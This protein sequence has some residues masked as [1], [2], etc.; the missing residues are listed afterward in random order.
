M[1]QEESRAKAGALTMNSDGLRGWKLAA[2]AALLL[3]VLAFPLYVIKEARR[4]CKTSAGESAAAT[5]VGRE[6]C[7]KCHAKAAEKWRGS[8]HDKA[9]AV[10]SEATVRGDFNNVTFEHNGVTSRFY[11]RDGRY[12]VQTEGARG[13]MAEFEVAYTFGFEPLQQYLVRFPGGRLQALSIAWDVERQRWFHLYP[14]QRIPAGDW[15]HWTRNAQ[16]WNGMCAECH[17]TDLRKGYD[18]KT[19]TY[20]TTWSEIDVSCEAC[21]GPGSL[22]VR[23][24]EIQPMARPEVENYG[25]VVRTQGTTARQQVELCAPCHSRRSE[26]GDYDHRGGDLLDTLLPVS[27]EQGLYFADGQIHDEV[28]EYGSFVQSKMFRSGVRC[29]DCHDVH[30]LKLLEPG[31]ALCLRCHRADTYDSYDHHFHKKVHDGKPSDGALCVKCHMPERPYMVID[32]RADHSIRVPRP[33]LTAQIGVPNA[34]AQSGCH[35]DKP[36]QWS[37]D[38]YTKWYGQA[39]KPHYGTILAAGRAHAPE[40]GGELGRLVQNPLYPPIVRATALSLLREYPGEETTRVLSQA[41]ADEESLVRRTAAASLSIQDARRFTGLLTPLL[42]DP[43]RGVRMEAAARLAGVSRDLLK[44]YQKEAFDRALAEYRDA[45]EH[46]LDFS[47]AGLNLGNLYTSLGRPDE[48]EKYYRTALQ[49]DDLFYPAKMNLAVLLNGEGRNEEAEKLLREVLNAYP[50][51]HEAAYSLGLLLAEMN[52][53]AEAADIL[54]QAAQGMPANARL[55]YNL[56]LLLQHLQRDA[57][58]EAELQTALDLEPQNVDYLYA[59]ADFYAKRGRFD[60][61]SSMAERMVAAQPD[62]RMGH[63]LKALIERMRKPSAV[64]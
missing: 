31:N 20:N 12:F 8:D 19:D 21:H 58:A 10:A 47:S 29:S 56:G 39:R 6:K 9:M 54:Q 7:V 55:R 46:S 28:Y 22:H 45:M 62:N 18:P 32:Y 2:T 25:L 27:L 5:F 17:S 4:P 43:V 35:D 53:H 40:A 14:D 23:W 52:R 36:V 16:N 38:A 24:A 37:V 50:E 51:Q 30:S 15:L 1:L 26:I 42:L 44:P 61:A 13:E 59:L 48:A 64:R 34:C 33:D 60:A 3:I 49:I 11:R 41:L 63:D 57:E